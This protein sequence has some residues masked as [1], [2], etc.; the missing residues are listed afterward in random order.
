MF[1]WI[2]FIFCAAVC[3]LYAA[4]TALTSDKFDNAIK[5]TSKI[6]VV[7]VF[8]PW[9]GPCKRFA[10]IFKEA[11]S[12]FSKN[13]DFFTVNGSEEAALVQRLNV[14]GYPTVIYFKGGKE[15]DRQVG[16]MSASEF[17]A[18]LKHLSP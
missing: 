18:Q 5:G 16:A 6:A 10:P 15:I 1:R 9:C 4:P 11:S 12:T 17:E 8:A 2:Q 13:F 7:D 14:Q 3:F